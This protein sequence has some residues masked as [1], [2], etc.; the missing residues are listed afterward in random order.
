M[1]EDC[2]C[3][4]Y[5]YGTGPEEDC[6]THGREVGSVPCWK[7]GGVGGKYDRNDAWLPCRICDQTGELVAS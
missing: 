2:T 3:L 7:C 6:P 4:P 1:S 5:P